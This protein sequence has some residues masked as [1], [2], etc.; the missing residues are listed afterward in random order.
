MTIIDVTTFTSSDWIQLVLALFAPLATHVWFRFLEKKPNLIWTGRHG[1]LFLVPA[2]EQKAE[3]KA[4]E[5]K[6]SGGSTK[7][8]PYRYYTR[9]YHFRNAGGAS[10]TNL[11]IIFNYK[12][13]HFELHEPLKYSEHLNPDGRFIIQIDKLAPKSHFDLELLSA[14]ELPSIARVGSDSGDAAA[15]NFNF[16]PNPSVPFKV[17]AIGAMIIGIFV[18][19][20]L[21]IGLIIDFIT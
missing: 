11:E 5:S 20:Y 19:A 7:R 18:A 14:F 16:I 13:E 9:G 6:E 1:F 21:A 4:T 3:A 8:N 2:T 17:F 12:P 15:K 10:V